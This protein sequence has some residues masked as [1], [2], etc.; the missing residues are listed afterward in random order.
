M[1]RDR[2]DTIFSNVI[3]EAA[4]YVCDRCRKNYRDR[5]MALHCSHI[6]GR[7]HKSVRAS[8]LNAQALCYPCHRWYGENPIESGSWIRE[9]L[10]ETGYERLLAMKNTAIR[11]NQQA[12]DERYA[13]WK[14]EYER[15]MGM[16]K[17]GVTGFIRLVDYQ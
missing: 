14:A 1:K 15:V 13:H 4:D 16:R 8:S 10:G 12:K 5:P 17:Q 11:W 3:R 2:L 7:Q 6:F 9:W